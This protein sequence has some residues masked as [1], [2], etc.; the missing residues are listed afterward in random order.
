MPK[1]G[2]NCSCCGNARK[3]KRAVWERCLNFRNP[4]CPPIITN[5]NNVIASN[6][7]QHSKKIVNSKIIRNGANNTTS[8]WRRVNWRCFLLQ[9][10]TSQYQTKQVARSTNNSTGRIFRNA[11]VI[12]IK[13]TAINKCGSFTKD[14]TKANIPEKVISC[15]PS[16]SS[17][18]LTWQGIVNLSA[19]EIDSYIG[20][21][22]PSC[23]FYVN[24]AI[25]NSGYPSETIESIQEDAELGTFL[26]DYL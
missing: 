22:L 21:E 16:T 12:N 10:Q 19:N 15:C 26:S 17:S 11:R 7:A 24:N 1:Q 6:P 4:S 9:Q 8:R 18:N 23:D 13:P 2:S 5:S 14:P 20:K 25:G 3:H